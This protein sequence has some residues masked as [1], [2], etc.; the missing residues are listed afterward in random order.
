M[1][2]GANICNWPARLV[3]VP[4]LHGSEPAHWQTWLE[5]QFSHAIR[6]EQSDWDDG[7]LPRW[8][9]RL[10]E[11]LACER[12]P[13][14]LAA[15]SFG[16]LVAAHAMGRGLR[17]VAGALLVAPA[18]PERFSVEKVLYRER[19]GVASIVVGSEND[20]WLTAAGARTLARDWGASFIN[21][22]R[23]GH[24]NVASGFGPWP[25]AK[26]FVDTL[27]HW[28]APYHLSIGGSS[29]C[30][31]PQAER[32]IGSPQRAALVGFN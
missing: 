21:L 3:V 30:G 5:R 15:H 17:N 14:V 2:S 20:P 11:R 22:G 27:A 9:A 4:G 8:C 19:L 32:F 25:R 13:F 10:E 12:G 6:V 18:S 28:A 24:I 16:C 1:S 7:D 23:A 31:L 26:Y 29:R